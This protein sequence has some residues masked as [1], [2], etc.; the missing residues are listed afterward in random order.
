[1]IANTLYAKYIMEREG[2]DIVEDEYG[3]I[4]YKLAGPECFIV[5]IFVD[6]EKRCS[7]HGKKLLAELIAKATECTMVTANI[8]PHKPGSSDALL[9]ALRA[10]FVV[11]RA[12]AGCILIAKDLM[13][14]KN[15]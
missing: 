4:I 8:W 10:G 1:M 3:F 13:E 5:D 14:D 15:G 2:H 6:K 9:G 7:G 11:K 12:E